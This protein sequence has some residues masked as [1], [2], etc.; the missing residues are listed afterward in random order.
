MVVAVYA[1]AFGAF[2]SP[3]W[4]SGGLLAPGDGTMYHV[5]A[6]FAP[7]TLWRPDMFAGFPIAAEPN[8]Q[9]HY[10]LL[11]LL[12][13]VGAFN[14]FVMS[15]YVLAAACTYGYVYHL[16]RSP[17]AA[18]A[19]GFIYAGGGFFMARVGHVPVV[20][21]AAWIPLM[22]WS[23]DALRARPSASWVA[24]GSLSIG[25][26]ALGGHPQMLVYGVGLTAA[27]AAVTGWSAPRPGR[28]YTTCLLA[29]F[30]GAGVGAAQLLP[31]AELSGASIRASISPHDLLVYSL[32][33]LELLQLL[34]PYLFTSYGYASGQSAY[35][36][37]WGL[38]ETSGYVGWLSLSALVVAIL[39]APQRVVVYFWS[40]VA[41]L[42]GLTALGETT[43]L[44]GIIFSLPGYSW[45]RCPA[46]H[47]IELTVAMAILA[48]LGLAAL[49]QAN[50]PARWRQA[51]AVVFL[52]AGGGI[53][54]LVSAG[55]TLR[56]AAAKAGI[57]DWSLVPWSNASTGVP[58]L[59]AMLTAAALLW[60]ARL[61][62][63]RSARRV[64]LVIVLGL[65][66]G[67][68]GW[69]YEWRTASPTRSVLEMPSFLR[70][71][72]DDVARDYTR[73]LTYQ[74]PA[75]AEAAAPN[76]NWLYSIPSAS[77][78]TSVPLQRYAAAVIGRV[79]LTV[80]AVDRVLDILAVRYVFFARTL[81]NGFDWGAAVD[82]YLHPG[83]HGSSEWTL[84][85]VWATHVA[86]DGALANSVRVA[87]GAPVGRLL[88]TT[89]DGDTKE[90]AMSAGTDLSDWAYDR[91][92]LLGKILHRRAP[93]F[94]SFPTLSHGK[95]FSRHD[96][97]ATVDLG[98]RYQVH[99]LALQ[100][101]NAM[102]PIVVHRL[103]VRDQAQASAAS[104]TL[105]DEFRWRF[106]G[107][108]ETVSVWE[109]RAVLPRAWLVAQVRTLEPDAILR[110]IQTSQLP[111][112]TR[113]DP[114]ELALVEEPVS[115]DSPAH[116]DGQVDVLKLDSSRVR[117]GVRAASPAFLVLSDVNYPGWTA[118]VDGVPTQIFQTDYLIRG[119]RVPAGAHVVEFAFRPMSV[120]AGR[121]IS[122]VSLVILAAL[123]W[124][125][126]P[127]STQD[128]GYRAA[129][130]S[131]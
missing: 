96:Y 24:M 43:P 59:M 125:W 36:G 111:D 121:A 105:P 58:L 82:L 17:F 64:V 79:P 27:Y 88:I 67:S 65:D 116:I 21:G 126:R 56:S 2:F 71:Y 45:F 69:F 18:L 61:D 14:V 3:V 114:R 54:V 47:L 97:L 31:T 91:P 13:L 84:N 122:I 113:F 117:L 120:Y 1:A 90:I 127:G 68:F 104:P 28:F 12:S 57:D 98:G 8:S 112:G 73:V 32:S 109:N 119:V 11:R 76:L 129:R 62:G 131:R 16:T 95:V 33:P 80:D 81:S 102:V 38:T 10:V 83:A 25:L 51:A 99:R 106:A 128:D 22:L 124:W 60:Q 94:E 78:Y 53:L 42:A 46:R 123:Q 75:P 5:P 118:S 34:F 7:G 49:D 20:H 85:D 39:H 74:F 35:F 115:L 30:L 44:A 9:T 108:S 37:A 93:V 29:L 107:A 103:R 101:T 110:S 92:D 130:R 86:I 4:L 89:S 26:C 40:S 66:L 77:G 19:S 41:V 6:F 63:H 55:D 87:D 48:G 70:R 72:R 100:P 23:T 15:A 50:E 52:M